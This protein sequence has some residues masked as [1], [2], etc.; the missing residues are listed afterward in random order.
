MIRTV[1]TIDIIDRLHRVP[2]DDILAPKTGNP[3]L[4]PRTLVDEAA[5]G[6]GELEG[7]QEVRDLLEV[8]AH[9]VDLMDDVLHSVDAVP[10]AEK[11]S[12]TCRFKKCSP[13]QVLFPQ[14]TMIQDAFIPR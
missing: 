10:G 2:N 3:M 8:W 14:A 11:S 1:G 6:G 9:G 13:L 4:S 7:P 12:V 5:L